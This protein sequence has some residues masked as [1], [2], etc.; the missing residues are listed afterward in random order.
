VFTRRR[1]R[2]SAQAIMVKERAAACEGSCWGVAK[3]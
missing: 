3:W 1:L 2:R